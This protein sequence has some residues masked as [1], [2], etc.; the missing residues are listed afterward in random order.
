MSPTVRAALVAVATS[1]TALSASAV[2]FQFEF[3]TY[4]D[5]TTLKRGDQVTLDQPVA[6]LTIADEAPG[7]VRF[8]LKFQDTDVPGGRADG[9]PFIDELWLGGGRGTLDEVSGPDLSWLAGYSPAGFQGEGGQKYNWDIQFV[10]SSFSE[11]NR[12]TFT[13]SGLGLT[14]AS[15]TTVAPNLQLEGVGRPY[16]GLFGWTPVNFV[17]SPVAIP[18]P[19]T[20]ALMGL[21]LAGLMLVRR[22]AA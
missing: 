17:G 10:P 18:E 11:G 4:Y 14:A 19:G 5:T 13:I 16:G 8:G 7:V 2:T 22:R 6:V 9:S 21:G 3:K 1:L 15:F 20:Y 12:A